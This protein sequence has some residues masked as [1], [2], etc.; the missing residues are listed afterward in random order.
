MSP[1]A[2]Q[3]LLALRDQMR[4]ALRHLA[5]VALRDGR[6]DLGELVELGMSAELVAAIAPEGT[7]AQSVRTEPA[8]ELIER[9]YAFNDRV[10]R[11]FPDL[12]SS[13][14]DGGPVH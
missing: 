12:E 5:Q 3:E 1:E 8:R 7:P 2:L 10:R 13:L 11:A 9:L 14:S 4:P 6:V